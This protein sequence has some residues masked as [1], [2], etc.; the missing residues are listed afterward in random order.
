VL[1]AALAWRLRGRSPVLP[2]LAVALPIALVPRR[3]PPAAVT[4]AIALLVAAEKLFPRGQL[5]G[6]IAGIGFVAAGIAV[7]L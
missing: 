3:L 5:L 1:G 4:A 7:A 2:A 6:K